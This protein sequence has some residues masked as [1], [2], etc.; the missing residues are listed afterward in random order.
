VSKGYGGNDIFHLS[1]STSVDGGLGKNTVIFDEAD[2]G[3]ILDLVSGPSSYR[4]ISSFTG[5]KFGDDM[6]G[7]VAS[8]TLSGS[9]GNDNLVGR[10]GDDTLIGGSGNDRIIGGA[11]RDALQGSSGDD[12]FIFE[13]VSD[14]TTSAYDVIADFNRSDDLIDLSKIDANTEKSGNQAFK[15]IGTSSFHDVAG[16]LRYSTANGST[17]IRG[18]IDGDGQTDF[19]VKLTGAFKLTSLD[20]AL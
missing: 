12:L 2:S 13:K 20:F 5:S 11:G 9:S 4:N 17:V 18:D 7:T 6:R 8:D 1:S 14:S 19:A 10:A 16:E 3:I 15:F